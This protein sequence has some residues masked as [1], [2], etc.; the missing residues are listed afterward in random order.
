[1]NH[2]TVNEIQP[3]KYFFV[4]FHVC[5]FARKKTYCRLTLSCQQ[6]VFFIQPYT[7]FLLMRFLSLTLF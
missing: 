7:L 6:Y 4:Y 1:M 5:F 2:S 3:L